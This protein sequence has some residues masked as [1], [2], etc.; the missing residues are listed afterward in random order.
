MNKE[1]L[2][3]KIKR[4]K[5]KLFYCG[6]SKDGFITVCEAEQARG[7]KKDKED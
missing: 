6:T 2:I 3:T 5:T 4:D 7:R 1:L